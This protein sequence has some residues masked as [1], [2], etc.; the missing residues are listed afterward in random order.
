M[1]KLSGKCQPLRVSAAFGENNSLKNCISSTLGT[2]W[3]TG[4]CYTWPE[5][6]LSRYHLP[7]GC[8]TSPPLPLL[9][10]QAAGLSLTEEF[11]NKKKGVSISTGSACP[12]ISCDQRMQTAACLSSLAIKAAADLLRPQP[13]ATGK[14]QPQTEQ[15]TASEH[16]GCV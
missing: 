10:A 8:C 14:E 6:G 9:G 16:P 3:Q 2:E 1:F 13:A 12:A 4:N 7:R 5:I 15:G 11:L